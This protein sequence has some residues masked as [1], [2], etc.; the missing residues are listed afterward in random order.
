MAMF[1]LAMI[2]GMLAQLF[3][4]SM[5]MFQK[6]M[7]ITEVHQCVMVAMRRLTVGLLN[8]SLE[9]VTL[10]KDPAPAAT[11]PAALSFIEVTG[12]S[13]S[14]SPVLGNRFEIHY[15]DR[16]KGQLKQRFWAPGQYPTLAGYTFGQPNPP[17]LSVA[18][19]WQI[20]R[21]PDPV[22]PDRVVARN[23]TEVILTDDDNN[24]SLLNPPLL[25]SVSASVAVSSS[26]GRVEK[27]SLSTRVTPRSMR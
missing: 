9:T 12:F 1:L 23:L 24:L 16:P 18:D 22:R 21:N 11:I 14:G 6:E 26:Q 2:M 5:W 3:L 13:A 4:P 20:C 25:L 15:F 17:V 8:T 27:W 10:V 19:L 7:A